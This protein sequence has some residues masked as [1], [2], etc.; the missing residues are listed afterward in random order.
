[1]I[2]SALGGVISILTFARW[3]Q[4]ESLGVLRSALAVSGLAIVASCVVLARR[5]DVAAKRAAEIASVDGSGG[6][7]S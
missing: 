4:L 7:A 5:D 2:V 1:M 6:R 3:Q